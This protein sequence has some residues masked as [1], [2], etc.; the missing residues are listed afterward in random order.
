MG[1]EDNYDAFDEIPLY[2]IDEDL[3]TDVE[4]EDIYNEFMYDDMF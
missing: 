3:M 4:K 2:D 1:P